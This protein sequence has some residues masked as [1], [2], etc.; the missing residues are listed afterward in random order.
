[1]DSLIIFNVILH[2]CWCGEKKVSSIIGTAT[3][4]AQWLPKQNPSVYMYVCMY[5]YPTYYAD[6]MTT[7][8]NS[9][10]FK[11]NRF[12]ITARREYGKY[13]TTRTHRVR[14]WKHIIRNIGRVAM[15][16]ILCLSTTPSTLYLNIIPLL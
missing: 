12:L 7:S 10:Y 4:L 6:S 13:V 14:D 1:M 5:V 8:S 3:S 15:F 11:I 9:N 2:V 16:F